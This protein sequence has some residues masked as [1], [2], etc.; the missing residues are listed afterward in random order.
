MAARREKPDSLLPTLGGQTGLNTAV[1]LAESGV[2]KK[3][4]VKLLANLRSIKKAE[5]RDRFKKTIQDI[6]LEVPRSGYVHNWEEAKAASLRR[7]ASR[8]SSVRP[9]PSAAPAATSPTT[10]KSTRS[11][12]DGAWSPRGQVLVEESVAGWKEYELEVMRDRKD[13]VVIVCSIENLRSH[14]HPHGRQHHR[15]RPDADR[16]RIPDHGEASLKI[17]RAIGVETGGS[18]IQFAVNPADGKLYV[19]EMNPQ[20]P[21]QLKRWRRRRPAFPSP[22]SPRCWRW[23]TRWTRS[24]VLN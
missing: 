17:I 7:S 23:A 15:A 24:Q 11:T 3:H 10:P 4:G 16:Q 2:L 20:G 13:N 6:G 14:G 9:T 12:S 1:A 8:P 22:R 18:N 19:I 21:A 5:E